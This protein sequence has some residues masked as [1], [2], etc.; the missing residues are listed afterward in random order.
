MSSKD[1]KILCVDDEPHV[2]QGIQRQ[3]RK[4]F[5]VETAVGAEMALEMIAAND[6]YAVVLSDMRMPGMDGAELLSIVKMRSPQSVR[7]ML[8]GNS[9]QQTAIEAT[10]RGAIFRFLNKPCPPEDLSNSL[11]DAIKQHRLII[12]EKELLEK[13]VR[14]SVKMLANVL[15]LARPDAFGCSARIR[16]IVSKICQHLNLEKAW[17]V[18][19]AA[20]MSQV[21][22]VTLPDDLVEKVSRNQRLTQEEEEL[23]LNHPQVGHDLVAHIPRMET[24]AQLIAYQK[25]P[26][27]GPTASPS[28]AQGND[29]PIGAR[30]LKAV[31]SFDEILRRSGSAEQTIAEM[32]SAS[33]A[34]D[35]QILELLE[36]VVVKDAGANYRPETLQICSIVSG[37]VLAQDILTKTGVLMVGKGQEITPSLSQRLKTF[38]HLNRIKGP[39]SVLVPHNIN[40]AQASKHRSGYFRGFL[41]F[42]DT[43]FY[44]KW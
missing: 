32:R 37:M 43:Y 33:D 30:I 14:G 42:L 20:M 35:P 44:L 24:V 21:G 13:T 17:Q 41:H 40:T 29:I 10:N 26:F 19:I 16:P 7:M 36:R 15:S 2:L 27:G 38:E 34:Y 28:Q 18:D 1:F 31:I 39:I 9:D 4:Q 5:C 3:L 11:I 25:I 23:F 12:A 22:W 6:P 8:T